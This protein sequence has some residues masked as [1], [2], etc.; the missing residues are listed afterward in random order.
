LNEVVVEGIEGIDFCRRLQR[1]GPVDG[2]ARPV[3]RGGWAVPVRCLVSRHTERSRGCGTLPSLP[4]RRPSVERPETCQGPVRAGWD[5]GEGSSASERRGA[6]GRSNTDRAPRNAWSSATTHV[7]DS[8]ARQIG[9]RSARNI[10]TAR[11][12]AWV[13]PRATFCATCRAKERR[14]KPGGKQPQGVDNRTQALHLPPRSRLVSVSEIVALAIQ[15]S[16][17]SCG[18][19]AEIRGGASG[20]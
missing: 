16:C 19:P 12:F 9:L 14:Q 5:G 10:S 8:N 15:R 13:L 20:L 4:R 3:P 7:L 18:F 6:S 11:R 1:R 17:G 2:L